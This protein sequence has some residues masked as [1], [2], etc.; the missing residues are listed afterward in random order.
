[1]PSSSRARPNLGGALVYGELFGHGPVGIV[2]L[3]DAVAVAVEAER[4]AA[5]GD[6]GVQS[7]HTAESIFRFELKMS[8]ENLAG[9]SS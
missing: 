6:H 8:G 2:A 9:A 1:M 5:S 4:H 3:K 7:A